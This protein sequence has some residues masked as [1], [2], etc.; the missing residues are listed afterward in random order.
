MAKRW[1]N[2]GDRTLVDEYNKMRADV[3]A[4]NTRVAELR[5]LANELKTDYNAALAKLDA[6]AGVTGTDYVA[7]HAVAAAAAGAV[8]AITAVD[9]LER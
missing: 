3:V 2:C 5:T 1:T 8:A 6:D 9:D 4:L 7:L